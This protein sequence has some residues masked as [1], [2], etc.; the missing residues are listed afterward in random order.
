MLKDPDL[1]AKRGYTHPHS[2][3]RTDGSEVLFWND[4]KVRK[5]ELWQRCGGRCEYLYKNGKRCKEACQ[6]PHHIIPRWPKRIDNLY[7]LLGLCR[8]HH[9]LIDGREVGGRK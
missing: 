9:R 4:W 5:V 2:F 6:D 7:N 1:K 3:V 8:E